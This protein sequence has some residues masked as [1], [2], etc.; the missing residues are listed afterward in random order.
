MH[1]DSECGLHNGVQSTISTHLNGEPHRGECKNHDD[2]QS[3][4]T[5]PSTLRFRRH[6]AAHHRAPQSHTHTHIQAG[7]QYQRY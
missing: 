7:D 6:I 1:A 2:H 4:Y 3:G 5:F